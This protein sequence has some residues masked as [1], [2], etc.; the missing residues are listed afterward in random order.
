[1]NDERP[2][3]RPLV[4]KIGGELLED[5]AHLTSVFVAV[6]RMAAAGS[7]IV[8]VHGGGKEIDAALKVA[9]LEKRQVDGLRITDDATLDVVVS[10][11]AGVVNTRLVAALNTAGVAAVG[12]TGADGACGLSTAAPPHQAVDGRLVDLGRV[13]AP[14]A[15]ADMRVLHTLTAGGF[16]PVIASI[17]MG[18]DGRLFNVNAD[19]FAGHLAARLGARRLVIAGTTPGVLDA[20]GATLP[21]LAADAVAGLVGNGTATAG[22][23]AKLRAGEHALA[24]GVDDVVIVDGRQLSA[25]EAAAISGRP[26]AA[27]KLVRMVPA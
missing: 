2:M 14:D 3:I 17:G 25:L 15:D 24:A 6:A 5:P 1:M 9:G 7:P 27:T 16:V 22:M 19:T 23:I 13:G 4:L 8:I 18:R 21:T 20:D 10:V 12:L 26:S 11:L